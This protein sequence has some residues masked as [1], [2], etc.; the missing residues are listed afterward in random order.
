MKGLHIS[1]V[2]YIT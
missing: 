2:Q 1:A